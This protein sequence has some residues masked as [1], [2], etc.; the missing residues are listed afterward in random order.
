MLDVC[1]LGCGGMMPLPA[2]VADCPDVPL[3]RE[4]PFD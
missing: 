1:L 3:Q 4:Q 2:Q